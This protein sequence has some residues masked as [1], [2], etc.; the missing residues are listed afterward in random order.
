MPQPVSIHDKAGNQKCL[1]TSIFRLWLV[2]NWFFLNKIIS[3]SKINHSSIFFSFL[4]KF[5]SFVNAFQLIV[6][7]FMP[8]SVELLEII[9]FNTANSIDICTNNDNNTIPIIKVPLTIYLTKN[10][11]TILLIIKPF[12]LVKT[13]KKRNKIGLSAR[14]TI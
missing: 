1:L 6:M 2:T 7:I 5:H 12:K 4:A 14:I 11:N 10:K 8:D 13:F 9:Y 3:L